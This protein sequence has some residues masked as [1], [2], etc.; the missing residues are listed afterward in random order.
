MNAVYKYS[1]RCLRNVAVSHV[2]V[3]RAVIR[4]RLA[5]TAAAAPKPDL[6]AELEKQLDEI[7]R[8][9]DP[10]G[11]VVRRRSGVVA[12]A[13]TSHAAPV[14]AGYDNTQ[15]ARNKPFVAYLGT[16]VH[17]AHCSCLYHTTQSR[18]TPRS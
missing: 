8:E 5:N 2:P 9:I 10:D 13:A 6:D 11:L 1:Y 16:N 15:T 17:I 18:T 4:P 14:H 7:L 12:A 3:R